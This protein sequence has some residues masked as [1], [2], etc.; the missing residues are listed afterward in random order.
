[1]EIQTYEPP[2]EPWKFIEKQIERSHIK[3]FKWQSVFGMTLTKA[4]LSLKL[5]GL[6]ADEVCNALQ[7]HKSIVLLAQ[8][9]PNFASE[10]QR[11]IKISVYARYGETNSL[12]NLKRE[13]YG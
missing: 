7:N 3:R 8:S 10:L 2:K 13:R 9:N 5:D 12:V 4:I 1:M 11:K 6:T